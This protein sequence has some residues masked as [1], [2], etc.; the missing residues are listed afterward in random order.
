MNGFLYG[1]ALQWKLDIRSKSLLV[2][3]YIVPF[4]FFLLMGGI[5]PASWGYRL[6]LDNG[7][8]LENLW[9]LIVVF[10]VAVIVCGVVLRKQK[11]K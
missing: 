10:F 3:C 8:Y 5:F 1:L 11:S 9:Y 4:I 6:M 2:T 7:F